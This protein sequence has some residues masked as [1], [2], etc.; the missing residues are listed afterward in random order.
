MELLRPCI[1]REALFIICHTLTH[2]NN[3]DLE[4]YQEYQCPNGSGQLGG[5]F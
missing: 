5:I 1:S 3:I 4:G 2:E